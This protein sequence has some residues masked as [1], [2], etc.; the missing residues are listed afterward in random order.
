[1]KKIC[2]WC[3]KDQGETESVDNSNPVTHGICPD[4]AKE[5]LSFKTKPMSAYL[6]KFPGPVYMLNSD[7]EIISANREGAEALGKDPAEFEGESVG[8]AFECKYSYLEGGCGAGILVK[9]VQ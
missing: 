5:V 3:N 1:M 6:D 4:C 9:P 7:C 8:K 2:A